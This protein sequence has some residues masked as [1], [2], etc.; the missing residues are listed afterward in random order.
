MWLPTVVACACGA[1][2]AHARMH[3]HGVHCTRAAVRTAAR[4]PPGWRH[5]WHHAIPGWPAS[6]LPEP[7]VSRRNSRLSF[8]E[9]EPPRASRSRAPPSV[10]RDRPPLDGPS[11]S[12]VGRTSP[13]QRTTRCDESARW[14]GISMVATSARG[15]M[16]PAPR[17]RQH[18]PTTSHM[19]RSP[20][21]SRLRPS[22]RL[23]LGD[24]CQSA[25]S[26]VRPL[27]DQIADRRSARGTGNF[28]RKTPKIAPPL[29]VR[30]NK[31]PS[32]SQVALLDPP[33]GTPV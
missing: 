29:Q 1:R 9:S 15:L 10:R 4:P 7:V 19:T 5:C 18:Q 16:P 25:A 27:L 8:H 28:S 3:V 2:P 11:L 21:P 23:A 26:S 14:P 33:G 17:W 13:H 32:P 22:C 30:P 12:Q 6:R 31:L 24:A 20:R